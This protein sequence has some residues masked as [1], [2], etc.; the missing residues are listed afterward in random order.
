LSGPSDGFSQHSRG[1][2][3]VSHYSSLKRD[4]ELSTMTALYI[5][6]KLSPA[7]ILE[8]L[9]ALWRDFPDLDF[10]AHGLSHFAHGL[11]IPVPY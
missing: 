4:D 9:L 11:L 5:R 3:A 8:P 2:D 1:V 6:V 7:S 10:R